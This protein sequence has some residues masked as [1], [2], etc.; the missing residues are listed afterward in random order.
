M[1]ET[2]NPEYERAKERILAT[3]DI[4]HRRLGIDSLGIKV[5]HKFIPSYDDDDHEIVARTQAV[6]QY[7]HAVVE[8]KLPAVTRLSDQALVEVVI[9]EYVHVIIAP[10][11][12]KL[13]SEHEELCE[14][15][16]ETMTR[17]IMNVAGGG[18]S[19]S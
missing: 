16:I 7:R 10:M 5:T 13:D 19:E 11:E 9:H 18:S 6:W 2:V 15:A 3:A 17:A 12:S 14:F 1:G 4:W 8:W